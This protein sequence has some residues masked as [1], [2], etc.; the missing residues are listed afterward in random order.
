MSEIRG[1]CT[2]CSN[3]GQKIEKSTIGVQTEPASNQETPTKISKPGVA[4]SRN[5]EESK[6]EMIKPTAHEGDLTGQILPEESLLLNEEA[7]P[8]LTL[9][10]ENALSQVLEKATE[11]IPSKSPGQTI[12]TKPNFVKTRDKVRSCVDMITNYDSKEN[13]K[14][15]QHSLAYLSKYQKSKTLIPNRYP[16]SA[17][18]SIKP[19]KVSEAKRLFTPP[20]RISP[21]PFSLQDL[22]DENTCTSTGKETEDFEESTSQLSATYDHLIKNI[23]SLKSSFKELVKLESLGLKQQFVPRTSTK[24]TPTKPTSPPQ[25]EDSLS[26]S[27]ICSEETSLKT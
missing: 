7:E 15:N 5:F 19:Q 10:F 9:S 6:L 23:G 24:K 22:V 13:Y 12:H 14:T 17:F 1:S 8:E 26:L 25:E 16:T 3:C 21:K 18:R 11:P 27:E 4:F 2:L 20:T